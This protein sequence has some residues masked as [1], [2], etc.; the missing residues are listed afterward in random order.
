MPPAAYGGIVLARSAVLYLGI[1]MS[2]K[3]A[4]HR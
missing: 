3:W 1:V 4:T 2:A